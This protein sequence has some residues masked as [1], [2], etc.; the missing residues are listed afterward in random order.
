MHGVHRP[1][2]MC[3]LISLIGEP[4]NLAKDMIP[5]LH[6]GHGM[7]PGGPAL[8]DGMLLVEQR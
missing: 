6:R 1:R 5:C 4:G 2:D 7:E 8:S 3:N